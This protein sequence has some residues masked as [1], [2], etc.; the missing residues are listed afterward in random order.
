[1]RFFADEE[2]DG[3]SR[4]DIIA[5]LRKYK[6]YEARY[7]FIKYDMSYHFYAMV[8]DEDGDIDLYISPDTY[9][10]GRGDILTSKEDIERL[11]EIY[12]RAKAL[13]DQNKSVAIAPDTPE[14]EAKEM[15]V[16]AM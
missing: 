7:Y 15:C 11:A 14:A 3:K 8:M 2:V 1:S 5:M 6:S 10:F 13:R 12:D 9:C 16:N 4:E